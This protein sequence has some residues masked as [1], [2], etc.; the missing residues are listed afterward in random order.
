MKN[1]HTEISG[2]L[3]EINEKFI[4]ELAA[5]RLKRDRKI[6][7]ILDDFELETVRKSIN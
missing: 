3:M 4:R 6:K 2:K 7:K 1:K 5:I